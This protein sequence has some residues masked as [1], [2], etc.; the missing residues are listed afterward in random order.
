MSENREKVKFHGKLL[1]SQISDKE[2]LLLYY[3]ILREN[4]RSF[5]KYAEIYALYDNMPVYMLLKRGHE[6]FISKVSF[7]GN[8]MNFT[9]NI[10]N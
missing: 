2:L 9:P 6:N 3:D 10:I 4:G 5:Q 8:S 1:R 7:G